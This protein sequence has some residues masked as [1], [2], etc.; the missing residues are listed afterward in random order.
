MKSKNI[1][2]GAIELDFEEIKNRSYENNLKALDIQIKI[3]TEDFK[4]IAVK[5]IEDILGVY[6]K[7]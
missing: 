2:T 6:E 1:I 3:L 5:Y 4:K 7:D